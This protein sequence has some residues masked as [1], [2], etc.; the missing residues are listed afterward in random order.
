M[1]LLEDII[2]LMISF[3]DF[4]TVINFLRTN[5]TYYYNP[6][7][8]LLTAIHRVIQRSAHQDLAEVD[9]FFPIGNLCEYQIQITGPDSST[10]AI[11]NDIVSRNYTKEEKLIQG[12]VDARVRQ[13]NDFVETNH[14]PWMDPNIKFISLPILDLNKLSGTGILFQD[15]LTVP[16]ELNGSEYEIWGFRGKLDMGQLTLQDTYYL[17]Y[18]IYNDHLSLFH[19]ITDRQVIYNQ[20]QGTPAID[21][22][23]KYLSLARLKILARHLQSTFGLCKA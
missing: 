22:Y 23:R 16:L 6:P 20:Y 10:Y 12:E 14:E 19:F 21:F 1:D 15:L 3:T 13:L 5:K 7:I 2:P 17:H 9:E 8:N 18:W 11:F 4:D